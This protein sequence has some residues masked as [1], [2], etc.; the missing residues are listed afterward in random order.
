[1]QLSWPLSGPTPRPNETEQ[2]S[3]NRFSAFFHGTSVVTDRTNPPAQQS[4]KSSRHGSLTFL[5][6]LDMS[7]LSS[8]APILRSPT[9]TRSLIDPNSTPASSARP[10]S[11]ARFELFTPNSASPAQAHLISPRF[12]RMI[13]PFTRRKTI[14]PRPG[15]RWQP[16]HSSG[17]ICFPFMRQRDM[18]TKVFHCLVS[19]FI[20]AVTLIVC[21]FMYRRRFLD[22]ANRPL[23]LALAMSNTVSGQEFH[24]VLILF[25][26][27]FTVIFCHSV[28]RLCML[29]LK[30]KGQ[31]HRERVR[32][33][34]A[35]EAFAQ[36]EQPIHVVLAMDEEMGREGHED[37]EDKELPPPPPAYGLWRGSVVSTTC[38]STMQN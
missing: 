1:M 24:I 4:R 26:L 10:L 35:T 36:P 7:H 14:R 20:L 32:R 17:R 27:V 2:R 3:S 13:E 12:D 22:H 33:R 9:S 23:V 38:L 31:R 19:G 28:I 29:F 37:D 15:P 5:P 34:L 16:R 25:L 6:R 11:T 30:S 8:N 21:T 18:R